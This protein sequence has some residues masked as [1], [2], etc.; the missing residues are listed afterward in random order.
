MLYGLLH[1][2]EHKLIDVPLQIAE[3]RR[4]TVELDQ[5]GWKLRQQITAA[6]TRQQH[7][8]RKR[9]AAVTAVKVGPCAAGTALWHAS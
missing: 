9:E 8:Q 6:A 2:V 7:L 1:H 4:Q 3:L 5:E